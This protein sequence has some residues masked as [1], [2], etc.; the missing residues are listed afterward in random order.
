VCVRISTPCVSAALA[1]PR[2]PAHEGEQ[3]DGD[4][5]P[6]DDGAQVKVTADRRRRLFA[7]ET[8]HRRALRLPVFFPLPKFCQC[9]RCVRSRDDPP[10]YRLHVDIVAPGKLLHEHRRAG[11]GGIEPRAALGAV[12]FQFFQRFQ[13]GGVRRNLAG[14]AAGRAPADLVGLQHHHARAGL[15]G[16]QRRGNSDETAAHHGNIRRQ[17]ALQR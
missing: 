7:I 4:A 2:Q 6:V 14:V 1:S 3:I 9:T 13:L 10:M 15:G 8:V 11:P 16:M 5:A 17:I 12:D